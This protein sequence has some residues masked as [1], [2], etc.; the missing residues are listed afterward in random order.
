[1]TKTVCD[2]EFD[3]ELYV[4]AVA[5]D[6]QLN[7][8]DLIEFNGY[9]LR[10]A[11][12]DQL[13]ELVALTGNLVRSGLDFAVFEN[14]ERLSPLMMSIVSAVQ[15]ARARIHKAL[16]AGKVIDHLEGVR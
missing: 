6:R 1:M 7:V 8:S 11:R 5:F 2:F 10:P 12:A 16:V 3:G 13:R 14:A 15:R 4:F 9:A